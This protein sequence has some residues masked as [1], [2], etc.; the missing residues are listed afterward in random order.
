LNTTLRRAGSAISPLA[1]LVALLALVASAAGVGYAAGQIGTNGIQNNAITAAKIKKNAVTAKKIKKNS[2][3]AAKVKDGSLSV[4]DLPS[5]EKYRTA[6]LLTGGEGD[7]IWTSADS[8]VPGLGLPSFRKDR[9]GVVHMS[10]VAIAVDGPGGDGACD[11]SDP[12]Q[13]NDGIAFTLPAG[14]V[15]FKS[16]IFAVGGGIGLLIAGP[17]GVV[18]PDIILPPGAVAVLSSGTPI[19]LDGISFEAAGAPTVAKL[20]AG[21]STPAAGSADVKAFLH[22]L[23]LT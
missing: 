19:A 11:P 9:D 18:T 12:G 22:R 8:E 13:S 23:G 4:A 21:R 1:L 10:G 17:N 7:C 14:Y 5:Q 3:T 20:A 2:I 16:M 6:T 15:P